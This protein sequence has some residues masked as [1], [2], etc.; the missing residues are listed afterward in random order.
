M[1]VLGKILG[2]FKKNTD[3]KESSQAE[4]KEVNQKQE[5]KENE[6]KVKERLRALGYI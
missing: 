2:I 6:E 4:S 5:E 3:V 1:N